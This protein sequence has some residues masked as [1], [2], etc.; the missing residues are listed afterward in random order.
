MAT[1][2]NKKILGNVYA[3][4]SKTDSSGSTPIK[5]YRIIHAKSRIPHDKHMSA[6]STQFN[7]KLDF[8]SIK[9]NINMPDASAR[10]GEIRLLII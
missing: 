5:L 9:V 2:I 10:K 3:Y 7:L 4:M 1:D 6:R 8:L